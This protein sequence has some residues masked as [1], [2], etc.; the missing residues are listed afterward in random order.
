MLATVQYFPNDLHRRMNEMI[1]QKTQAG[2]LR[3]KVGIGILDQY[4]KMFSDI[5]YY[6]NR[7][8]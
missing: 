2:E 8:G 7:R 1:R 4:K 6:R 3:P 5:T